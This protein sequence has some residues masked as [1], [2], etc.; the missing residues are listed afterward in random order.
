M[1]SDTVVVEARNL[2]KSYAGKPPV[3][4]LQDVTFSVRRG[5]L[6]ALQGPSGSGKSTL[7]HILGTIDPPTSGNLSICGTDPQAL[8]TEALADF[9]RNNVGFVFQLFHL[10]AVLT[11]IENVMLPLVPY[12]RQYKFDLR[13]RA[14][15]LLRVVGIADRSHHLPGQLSGGE[16]QRVAIAR[17]LINQP[18]LILADEPTGNLDS[19]AGEQVLD[20]LHELNKARGVTVLVVTHD[21]AIASR[22]DRVLSLRDGHLKESD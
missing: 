22:A 14:Y 4:A 3:R 2:S 20:L 17:A 9:R 12:R 10:V 11:A 8:D 18:S 15:E 21:G 13:D 19:A 6:V 16:Q 7:L 5:E 1:S